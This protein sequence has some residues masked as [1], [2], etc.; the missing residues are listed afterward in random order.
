M[1][2]ISNC[3]CDLRVAGREVFLVFWSLMKSEVFLVVH[4]VFLRPL[5]INAVL[6]TKSVNL[7]SRKE[8]AALLG[9]KPQTLAKWAM[10][11]KNL[12]VIRLGNRST[13]YLIEEIEEFIRKCTIKG[14]RIEVNHE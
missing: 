9:L 6:M 11:G 3:L 10:T 7:C 2:F 5:T 14:N 8:A 13:R 12:S 1:V 4:M